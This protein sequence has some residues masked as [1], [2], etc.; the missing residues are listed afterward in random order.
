MG[1]K[2]IGAF[3]DLG[4]RTEKLKRD[5]LGKRITKRHTELDPIGK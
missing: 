1:P 3:R 4:E 2:L 5:F